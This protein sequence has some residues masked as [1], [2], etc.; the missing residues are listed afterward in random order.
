ME[1][2]P[3]YDPADLLTFYIYGYRHRI[4]SSRK[5]AQTCV[6]DP[7]VRWLLGSLQDSYKTIAGFRRINA[8]A[9]RK[10]FRCLTLHLQNWDL[11]DAQTVAIDPVKMRAQNSQKNLPACLASSLWHDQT[12]KAGIFL[13]FEAVALRGAREGKKV[14]ITTIRPIRLSKDKFRKYKWASNRRNTFIL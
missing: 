4:R 9:F 7:E 2:F 6:K 3:P 5:L 8:S 10:V 13:Y 11:V 1:G 12:P 14:K